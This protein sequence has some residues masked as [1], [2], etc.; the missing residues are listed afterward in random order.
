MLEDTQEPRD[1]KQEVHEIK[2]KYLTFVESKICPKYF[3]HTYVIH[4]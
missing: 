2:F 1:A 4:S 3:T